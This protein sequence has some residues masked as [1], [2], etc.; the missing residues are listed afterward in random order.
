MRTFVSFVLCLA[1]AAPSFAAELTLPL[2]ARTAENWS[3][4]GARFSDL[5]RDPLSLPAGV[6]LQRQFTAD[7]LSVEVISRPVFAA[8]PEDW[9]VLELG[10]TALVFAREAGRGALVLLVG[11]APPEVHLIPGEL[12]A[13]GRPDK[14]V[15]IVLGQHESGTFLDVDG[16]RLERRSATE[17]DLQVVFSTGGGLAMD[18]DQAAVTLT[19]AG[20]ILAQ[21]LLDEAAS[22]ERSAVRDSKD[23]TGDETP[24]ASPRSDRPADTHAKGT[25]LP[26]GITVYRPLEIA[27]PPSVRGHRSLRVEAAAKAL[28]NR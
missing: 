8:T 26:P 12:S 10:S 14:P 7:R 15:H 1:A 28:N 22:V 13:D 5:G 11:D 9:A 19:V 16:T 6:Q 18:L 21:S 3:L 4:S 25:A 23:R 24:L 20:E 17:R 2:T 27:T